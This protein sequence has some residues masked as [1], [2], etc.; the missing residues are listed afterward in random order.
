MKSSTASKYTSLHKEEIA[1]IKYYEKKE[2]MKGE[3]IN[4]TTR[5][6]L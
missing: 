5:S 2:A 3:N 6:K 4:T 1:S